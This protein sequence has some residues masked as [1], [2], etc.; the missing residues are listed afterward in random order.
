MDLSPEPEAV[1]LAD[2]VREFVRDEVEPV[3][4]EWA[5]TGANPCDELRRG[6]QKRA[7]DA[8]LLAPTG[9]RR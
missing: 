3:E 5:A 2:R 6:L 8:G 1:E 7:A 4:Q 9:P